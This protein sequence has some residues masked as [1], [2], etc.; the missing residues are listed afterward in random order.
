MEAK[1]NNFGYIY[2]LN[3]LLLNTPSSYDFLI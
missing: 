3:P 1:D 2:F